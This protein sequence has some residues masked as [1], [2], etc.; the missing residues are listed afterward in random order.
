MKQKLG[1]TAAL[2]LSWSAINAQGVFEANKLSQTELRGTA[3]SMSMGGAFGALGG[4]VSAIAINPAGIGV[5][6]SSEI[7][8]TLDFQNVENKA[9]SKG[10]SATENKFRV[11]F[12]NLA[13][14]G[15]FPLYND[16]APLINFGFSYNKVKSFE[17]KYSMSG[18]GASNGTLSDYMAA[19]AN[20]YKGAPGDWAL[21]GKTQAQ[22]DDMWRFDDWMPI[23]GQNG[24]LFSY[25]GNRDERYI[26]STRGMDVNN[27]LFVEEKGSVDKY[28]FNIGTTFADML[29]AGLTVSV[30]DINY[31]MHSK[32]VENFHDKGLDAYGGYD[33]YNNLKTEGTGWQL[34]L[35]VIFK[36][37]Q[38][39]RLGISYH[40]PTWYNMTD[41]YSADLNDNFNE[42]KKAGHSNFTQYEGDGWVK[43]MDGDFD[44]RA[45]YKLRTPDMWTFSIAGVLGGNA[46][47]SLDYELVD[48]TKS[49]LKD[50]DGRVTEG[51]AF[52][53]DRTKDA[54]KL[55]STLRVGAEYRITSQFSGRVGYSWQESPYSKDFLNMI[56]PNKNKNWDKYYDTVGSVPHYVIGKDTHYITW[57]LGYRF[58]RNFYT[59]LA[60]VYKTQKG[61]LYT[62][63]MSDVTRLKETSVQAALTMGFKF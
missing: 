52:E 31:R 51:N 57:G 20:K 53:N 8:A 19:R 2:L 44:N 15:T 29:S 62:H 23:F 13:F 49:T 46:I 28:D 18:S 34:G 54:Y 42:M 38:E 9:T 37:V 7:V 4:D 50:R 58:T 41:Y 56:N 40:S 43:S 12:N 27:S 1:I 63:S 39:L 26:S 36:P 60:F 3:R 47:L 22:R 14:V 33:L 59:D 32:N 11:N 25:D 16:V 45:E 61:E 17:R 6:K 35:G 5:Y 30:T 24:S 21:K 55:T 10:N 48:Y